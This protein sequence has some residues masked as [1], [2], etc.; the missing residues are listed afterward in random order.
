MKKQQHRIETSALV[1]LVMDTDSVPPRW[2]IDSVTM[3]G[4]A[5]D[6]NG[7]NDSECECE[8]GPDHDAAMQLAGS[9]PF[10]NAGQLLH[11][12]LEAAGVKP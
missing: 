11:M 4:A 5:L 12:L 7:I 3:D 8:R 9:L 1:Y 6:D 2:E 10:P